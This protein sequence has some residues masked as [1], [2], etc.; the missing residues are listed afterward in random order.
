MG[1]KP[2]HVCVPYVFLL[3]A[4][5]FF[6]IVRFIPLGFSLYLSFH[7]WDLLQKVKPFVGFQNFVE[8]FHDPVFFISLYNSLYYVTGLVISRVPLALFLAMAVNNI[9]KPLRTPTR[10]IF[11]LPR[12]SQIV[13]VAILWKWL[14][15]PTFGLFNYLIGLFGIPPQSWLL[16]PTL[17]K[18]SL[19]L[20]N[21]WRD[22]G[23]F[24]I[25]FL[26]GLQTI[27]HIYYEAA[28]MDGASRWRLFWHITLPLLKPV[29]VFV[30]VINT[31]MSLQSF[32][33]IYVTTLGGP[34]NASKVLSLYVYQVA[35]IYYKLGKAA[36]ASL[37]L[38]AIIF[39]FAYSQLKF[40]KT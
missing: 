15:D 18:P 27:P 9:Y 28:I 1:K 4:L 16:S 6:A 8:I 12:I 13:A 34:G 22:V 23:Y 19:I 36:S 21:T 39:I 11:F 14:Y 26:A 32:T 25:I 31:V 38:G 2:Y 30:L 37:I 3:P 40:T 10:T 7:R 24:M 17:V 5:F 35:F 33:S 29:I 20:M